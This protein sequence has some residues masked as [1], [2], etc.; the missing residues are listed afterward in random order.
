MW[1]PR[2]IIQG[3]A[4]K[5]RW[6]LWNYIWGQ[7]SK[8]NFQGQLPAISCPSS[9]LIWA[10]VFSCSNS[11]SFTLQIYWQILLHNICQTLVPY[12]Q[13]GFYT[14]TLQPW[15]LYQRGN[16]ILAV[17]ISPQSPPLLLDASACSLHSARMCS[18]CCA[19]TCK[20]SIF[21]WSL[22]VVPSIW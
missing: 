19:N 3:K 2:S 8:V 17:Y 15:Q 7:R 11:I 9:L 16:E 18:C 13:L 1:G 12:W 21:I 4:K 22:S 14:S 5:F 10:F 20:C 6:P